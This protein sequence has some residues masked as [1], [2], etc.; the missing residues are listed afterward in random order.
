MR[1]IRTILDRTVGWVLISLMAIAVVNVL[2]QV[3][4]RYVLDDALTFSEPLARSLLVWISVIGAGYAVGARSH[5]AIDLLPLLLKRTRW[6][7][8]L[9]DF[10]IH[11]AVLAFA[12][13]V[14]IIGG[15][16]YVK[17][18]L[19]TGE[20]SPMLGVKVGY[21][22]AALPAAGGIMALYAALNVIDRFIAAYRGE[23]PASAGEADA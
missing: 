18:A 19:E 21:I 4:W 6:L 23:P 1:M 12:V 10:F 17:T 8:A 20:T 7:S 16:S 15:A 14:L 5:L 11:S 3:F 13:L 22:Y 2:A 9:L